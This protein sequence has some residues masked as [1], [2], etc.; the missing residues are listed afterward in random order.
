M[1][2]QK[3]RRSTRI[4]EK[5]KKPE[6]REKK[7]LSNVEGPELT[8]TCGDSSVT[9]QWCR[10]RRELRVNG[11][12]ISPLCSH[13]VWDPSK[14]QEVLNSMVNAQVVC[15]CVTWPADYE[16][17]VVDDADLYHLGI[18]HMLGGLMSL[19][20]FHEPMLQ[21][22]NSYH[23]CAEDEEWSYLMGPKLLDGVY[24]THWSGGWDK[25]ALFQAFHFVRDLFLERYPKWERGL[26][27][28]CSPVFKER[29]FNFLLCL[30]KR[31]PSVIKDV[32]CLIIQTLATID[33]DA[34]RGEYNVK[35]CRWLPPTP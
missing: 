3:R 9:L 25:D 18:L 19:A 26:H 24:M 6:K 1:S 29:A 11:L 5:K 31:F 32:R 16:K 14:P 22:C 27:R 34:L 20:F 15:H 21:V 35:R 17:M 13:K 7:I 4:K 28:F 10:G 23:I 8:V 12:Y 30:K 2:D 33:S